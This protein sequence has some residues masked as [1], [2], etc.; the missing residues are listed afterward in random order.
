MHIEKIN[1]NQFRCTLSKS[2]LEQRELRL[3]EL[4]HGSTKAR[5]LLHELIQQASIELDIDVENIPLMVEAIPIADGCLVLVVTRID[6]PEELDKKLSFLSKLV[7]LMGDE[8]LDLESLLAENDRRLRELTAVDVDPVV[9]DDEG[10]T[11]LLPPGSSDQNNEDGESIID[12]SLDPLGLIA[13]FAR[14]LADARKE[15]VQGKDEQDKEKESG[16]LTRL[17]CFQDLDQIIRLSAFLTPFYKGESVLYKDESSSEYYL[18]LNQKESDHDHYRRAC[19]IASEFGMKMPVSYAS[20]G[21]CLEHCKCMFNG[22]A[23][24]T[25]NELN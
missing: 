16:S 12:S 25:L 5:E 6:D 21:Y 3:S 20:E 13:P 10:D 23:L 17:F 7:S 11:R 19:M 15:S 18:F 22:D 2:D 9:D 24:E 1:E 14:A 4:A 8:D